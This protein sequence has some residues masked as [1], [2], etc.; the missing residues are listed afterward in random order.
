MYSEDGGVIPA[1][2][3]QEE[4]YGD[5]HNSMFGI[6][7]G[8]IRSVIYSDNPES[9]SKDRLEYT[10]RV[11]G[12]DY[13]NAIDMRTSGGQFNYVEKVLHPITANV[14][15]GKI[16]EGTYEEKT[17]G[18]TVWVMFIRGMSDFPLIVGSQ[19]SPLN[20]KY[21]QS[22]AKDGI[23]D[24]KEL[25]GMEFK[26]D[27]DGNYCVTQVG[28]KTPDGKITNEDGVGSAIKFYPNGNYEINISDTVSLKFNKQDKKIISK[29]GDNSI[30]LTQQEIKA[31]H[32]TG[33]HITIESGGAIRAQSVSQA[34][35][36][37]PKV[38]IG[39]A[40]VEL[41][42]QQITALKAVSDLCNSMSKETHIGNLAQPTTAP[43]NAGAYLAVKGI[44]DSV[45]AQLTGLKGNI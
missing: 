38:A 34:I 14:E 23:Y 41:L 9:H 6:Y 28:L 20:R 10:V 24:V 42:D 43:L 16:S 44:I 18:E 21:Q 27:K 11:D 29:T 17:N 8:V 19:Q 39:N 32:S 7:K 22:K 37:A 26:V 3:E 5:E 30:T 25:N 4:Y 2:I 31:E 45:V 33:S 40:G 35:L 15:D 12:Q 13:Q 1:G 36:E